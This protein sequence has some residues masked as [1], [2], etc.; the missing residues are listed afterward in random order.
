M[1]FFKI[2]EREASQKKGNLEIYPDFQVM[3]SKDL[4]IR[5]KSFYAIWDDERGLWSTDEFDVQRL[6]DAS[7]RTYEVQTPGIFEQHRKYLGNFSTSSWMQFRHYVSNLSDNHHELDSRLTF[8]NTDVKK[9]DYV[10]RRLPYDLAEG[11]IS[12]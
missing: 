2:K 1:D 3:R 10:S 7:I 11:D 4:M 8:R 12:A 9:E 6:V 5:A